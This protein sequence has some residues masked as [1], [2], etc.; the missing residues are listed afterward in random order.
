M[1]LIFD[2]Y[3]AY[4]GLVQQSLV[5]LNGVSIIGFILTMIRIHILLDP[6]IPRKKWIPLEKRDYGP[7][8]S[9]Q[10]RIPYYFLTII[11]IV[12][13]VFLLAAFIYFKV[14]SNLFLLA[15]STTDISLYISSSDNIM[16]FMRLF[17][18]LCV[19]S[20]FA[21]LT[22]LNYP[23]SAKERSFYVFNRKKNSRS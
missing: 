10:K 2:I 17:S 20:P 5:I 4:W 6:S 19:M 3:Q 9:L 21:I 18:I 15:S 13:I 7:V 22:F 14:N 1:G 12:D 8:I 11:A 16:G 23:I